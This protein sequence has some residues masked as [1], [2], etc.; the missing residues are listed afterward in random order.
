MRL[1]VGLISDN[2]LDVD[3][4]KAEFDDLHIYHASNVM[5]LYTIV[6][7][8]KVDALIFMG[9]ETKEN[10]QDKP[11]KL[12]KEFSSYH[13]YIRQ[14]AAFKT[15]PIAV[16]TSTP[17]L[18]KHVVDDSLVRC[19]DLDGG[20][21]IPLMGLF[22]AIQKKQALLN[23]LEN[24]KIE[25]SFKAALDEAFG[26]L[27]DFIPRPATD[28]EAHSEFL[29]QLSDE[30]SSNLVWIKY[31]ARLLQDGSEIFIRSSGILH[32][33]EI[34]NHTQRTL[35]DAFKNFSSII[36]EE[37]KEEGALF[38]AKSDVIPA[39]EKAAF[40]KKAKSHTLLFDSKLCKIAVEFI[41]YI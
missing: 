40:I 3:K 30:I 29:V 17:M 11:D 20:F 38:F 25:T 24:Q 9:S 7:G 21:F 33:D 41:R 28:D 12:A 8:N 36:I 19:H 37:L 22:E 10:D 34:A 14:K 2:K 18:N 23:P 35:A 5:N 26:P 6:G 16:F 13:N 27:V 15:T 39:A 1:K 32:E 4:M 31:A